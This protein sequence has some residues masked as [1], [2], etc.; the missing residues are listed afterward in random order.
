MNTASQS[1]VDYGYRHA[2][3]KVLI[4]DLGF[5]D[6]APRPGDPLPSFDL[7]LTDAGRL[8]HASCARGA[9]GRAARTGDKPGRKDVARAGP[10]AKSDLWRSAPPMAVSLACR[11][12]STAA[13]R[14]AHFRGDGRRSVSPPQQ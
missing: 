13:A 14:V 3:P 6:D 1:N 2:T 7:P 5:R 11:S 10:R 12:V 9:F 4:E 8:R